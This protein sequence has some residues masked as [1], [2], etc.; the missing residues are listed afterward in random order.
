[1]NAVAHKHTKTIL[2]ATSTINH[3]N[4]RLPLEWWRSREGGL[5]EPCIYKQERRV[6][7]NSQ[8]GKPSNRTGKGRG[9]VQ[10][11]RAGGKEK[12]LC[13]C[14][15]GCSTFC[16]ALGVAIEREGGKETEMETK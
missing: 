14:H 12:A 1:M 10:K 2:P 8:P 7:Q 15:A 4:P 9:K 3:T 13:N 11:K 6:L 16:L 5:L